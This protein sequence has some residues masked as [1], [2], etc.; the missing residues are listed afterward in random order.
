[1]FKPG[2]KPGRWQSICDRCGFKYHSDK[3][4]KEWTG[5]MVCGGCYE[6]RNPQDFLRVV[7]ERIVPPWVRDEAVDS[8]AN[9]PVCTMWTSSPFADVA[10]ADCAKVN[11]SK[12]F[13]LLLDVFGMPAIGNM[14]V[15]GYLVAGRRLGE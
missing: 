3:L 12:S 1:M 8:F 4:Q 13:Q 7:P 9:A 15:A 6:T 10:T 2:W 11:D 14:A 5:L